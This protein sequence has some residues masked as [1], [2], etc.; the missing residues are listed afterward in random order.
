MATKKLSPVQVASQ[1]DPNLLLFAAE[2]LEALAL[3]L[4][5]LRCAE[6]G[7]NA[8]MSIQEEDARLADLQRILGPEAAREASELRRMIEALQQRPKTAVA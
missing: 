4:E 6:W 1:D 5:C 8:K 3:A 7:F 2:R